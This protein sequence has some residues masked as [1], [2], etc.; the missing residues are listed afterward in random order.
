VPDIVHISKANETHI[1]IKADR[2]ILMELWNH[3]CYDHP[4][5]PFTPAFKEKR[6]DGKV[7]LLDMRSGKLPLGLHL[8]TKEYCESMGYEVVYDDPLDVEN[9]FSVDEFRRMVAS[10]K[11]SVE[12]EGVREFITPHD[13]QERGIIH[14]IQASRSL[15]LSA[16]ACHAAGTE[17]VMF[18]GT[19][20]KVEDIVIGDLLMGPDS[21][22]RTVSKLYH[23]QD[24]MFDVVPKDKG[25]T[26]RVNSNHILSLVATNQGRGSKRRIKNGDVCNISVAEYLTKTKTFKHIY[27]LYRSEAISFPIWERAERPI[28]SYFLGVLLGDGG[29]SGSGVSVTTIDDEIVQEIYRQAEIFGSRIRHVTKE[30]T[31]AISYF[32]VGSEDR[33][34][35]DNWLLLQLQSLGLYPC[36]CAEKFI[37]F[38]YKVG[39]IADRLQLLAGII[40]TDGSYANNSYYEI[41][42]KSVT[43][44][45]DIAFVARSLGFYSSITDKVVKGVTYYRINVCGD[46]QTIPVKIARKKAVHPTRT[47][48]LRTGFNVHPVG[49]G[50]YFGFELDAD[51][52]YLLK[53]F[54]VTH[55]SGKSLMIYVLLRYYLAKT[56]GKILIIVPNTAL[57]RQLFDD[58]VDYA[59]HSNWDAEVNCHMVYDG[60]EKRTDKRVTI[61]TWQALAVKERLPKEILDELKEEKTPAQVKAIMR[62]WNKQAPYIL[63]DEFF[64]EFK[65]VFG[66]E[67]L[68]PETN[69]S[70][71][72]GSLKQIQHVQP[73]DEVLTFNE[74]SKQ[75]ETKPVVKQHF[76]ISKSKQM[77][78][79]TLAD[80]TQLQIT[81]NHKVKLRSG[82]WR[83]VDELVENDDIINIGDEEMPLH[84]TT[85]RNDQADHAC[86]EKQ[87]F[88]V[89]QKL[90]QT[91]GV[92]VLLGIIVW[93]CYVA[94]H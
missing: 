41:S 28:E 35:R 14:A 47:K 55:N 37:P 44:A 16:T 52:L 34:V 60:G 85:F 74:Q 50:E 77:F 92:L 62:K 49:K 17:V 69:I 12:S 30:E 90:V 65:T 19:T 20:K 46:I 51:H 2:S 57:V 59:H 15:L 5:A 22:P 78:N 48:T 67:C 58:F 91:T 94:T 68:H 26:F 31:A 76:N 72:D 6:W 40:D 9:S 8:L 13:Y 93:W 82:L 79:L 83:R 21:T 64:H 81:G 54:T 61:S 42:T 88:S 33:R 18:N 10:L 36:S 23:G 80:G 32:F 73:G 66:D 3:F 11:L 45:N 75:F 86:E 56:K 1:R 53:D 4:K 84:E 25:Y 39:S 29:M 70:M 38:Q 89:S 7:R 24:E 87:K 43:L 27:K 71:A 63:E